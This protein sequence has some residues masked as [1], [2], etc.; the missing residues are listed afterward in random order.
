LVVRTPEDAVYLAKS[1]KEPIVPI[2]LISNVTGHNIKLLKEFLNVLPVSNNY[3]DSTTDTEFVVLNKFLVNN[4]II[5]T[6]SV[7]QG[8]VHK[9]NKM[10]LGP[11]NNQKFVYNN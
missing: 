4:K 6:G 2:F 10:Y 9:H 1:I 7:Y 8:T 5:L 3:K 11:L